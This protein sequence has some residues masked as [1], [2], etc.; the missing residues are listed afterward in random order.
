MYDLEI[1]AMSN[2]RWAWFC[3]W[4]GQ[5][6]VEDGAYSEWYTEEVMLKKVYQSA[7]VITLDELPELYK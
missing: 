1:A 4:V 6:V 5:F 3:A 2:T 7:N